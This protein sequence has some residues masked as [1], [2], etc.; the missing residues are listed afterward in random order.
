MATITA[1]AIGLTGTEPTYNNAD[2]GGDK[3]TPTERTFLHVKNGSAGSITATITTVTTVIGQAVADV[4]VAIP[5]GE[6]RLIGPFPR[7][8]FAGSDGLA[9]VAWSAT[10][11]V[12]FA[13]VRI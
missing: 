5:A 10:A 7:N 2:A 11:S 12:T 9:D 8:H 13:V 4:A 1:D 6:E 3:F